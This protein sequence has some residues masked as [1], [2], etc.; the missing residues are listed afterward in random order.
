[1]TSWHDARAVVTGSAG[2]IGSHLVHALAERGASVVGIDRRAG[3]LQVDLTSTDVEDVLLVN[4]ALAG[5]DVVFHLAGLPGV[6]GGGGDLDARRQRDNVAA[7]A[8]VLNSTPA[9]TPVVVTSSS[10]VYGGADADAW[11]W[12]RPSEEGDRLR[13]RGGYARSKVAL[14]RLCARRAAEGGVVAVAR[15]FTVAGEGQRPDMAVSRWLTAAAAGRPLEVY[16]GLDRFRD[17]TDV[18]DV[19][20]GLIALAQHGRSV[21]VNLGTGRPVALGEVVEAVAAAAGRPVTVALGPAG[22]EEV[23]A[24]RACVRRCEDVLGFVPETDLPDL[25]QRQR[26]Y[27]EAAERAQRAELASERAPAARPS[28]QGM[29]RAAASERD[30]QVALSEPECQSISTRSA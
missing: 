11:G 26:E 27:Q 2:F 23:P 12:F 6:R 22:A 21:T 13:P 8:R 19:V 20:R 1:V 17:V 29:A 30:R 15:P 25:V 10:S 7:G 14:E 18:R 28:H 9:A 24:T 3:D 16:G 5:A 4:E